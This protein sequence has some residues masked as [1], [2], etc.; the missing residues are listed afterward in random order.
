MIKILHVVGIM[1]F[2]GLET[3]IMNYYRNID[4]NRF[5]FDFVVHSPKEGDYDKEI[6][7]LGGRIYHAP[8]F[9]WYDHREYSKWWKA[10]LSEQKYD[11]IHSHNGGGAYV[12]FPIARKY[13][14]KTILH[15]HTDVKKRSLKFYLNKCRLNKACDFSTKFFACSESAGHY[16]FKKR[17]FT[18]I[19][20]AIDQKKFE[21]NAALRDKV[22]KN[23]GLNDDV[24]LIGCVGRLCMIKNPFF[25]LKVFFEFKKRNTNAQLIFLGSGEME[26]EL[27]RNVSLLGLNDC[28]MILPAQKN[29]NEFYMAMDCLLFPSLF[30]GLGMVAIEAQAAGLPVIMSDRVPQ[31]AAIDNYKRISLDA[32]IHDWIDALSFYENNNRCAGDKKKIAELGFDIGLEAKFLMKEYE[33]ILDI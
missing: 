21:Y 24:F 3:M 5:S 2:A 8:V 7:S 4:R 10:L 17:E 25:S 23:L 18:I 6:E 29:V 15:S 20:N 30:E 13:G 9:R 26:A 19:N 12:F 31:V 16:M 14:V 11:I 32:P 22:R 1:H 33:K 28:V 27:K